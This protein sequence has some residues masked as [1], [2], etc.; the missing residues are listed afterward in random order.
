MRKGTKVSWKYGTGTATGKIEETHKESVT[1]K[2]QGSEITRNGTP[3]NPAFL[4]VQE[5]GDKVLKLQ[6]EV[7]EAK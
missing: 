4:I 3:E 7:K 5:N 6:S 1:R 2:L